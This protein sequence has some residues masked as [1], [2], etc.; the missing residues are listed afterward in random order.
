MEVAY[1]QTTPTP[2]EELLIP[3]FRE[4]SRGTKNLNDND[5]QNFTGAGSELAFF[6]CILRLVIKRDHLKTQAG[7]IEASQKPRHYLMK[8]KLPIETVFLWCS[9][10]RS[11]L[12][13]KIYGLNSSKNANQPCHVI[14]FIKHLLGKIVDFRLFWKPPGDVWLQTVVIAERMERIDMVVSM[15]PGNE[16]LDSSEHG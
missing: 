5:P 1:K 14:G 6:I 2:A 9:L 15:S 3:L 16:A 4:S 8:R 13:S 10:N 11:N 7:V 12:T